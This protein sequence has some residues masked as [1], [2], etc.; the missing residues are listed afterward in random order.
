VLEG[1]FFSKKKPPSS[2]IA[3]LGFPPIP[4]KKAEWMGT[5]VYSKSENSIGRNKNASSTK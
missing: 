4:Q 5:K 3:K 2:P 1:G